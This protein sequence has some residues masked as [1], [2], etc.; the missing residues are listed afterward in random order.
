M[1]V[2]GKQED[3]NT[4]VLHQELKHICEWKQNI[5]EAAVMEVVACPIS[6]PVWLQPTEV[7]YR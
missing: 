5:S 4:G 1:Y 2:A 3:S 6:V 7:Q